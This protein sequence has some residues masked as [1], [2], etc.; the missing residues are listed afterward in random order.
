MNNL[1]AFITS[2]TNK[3]IIPFSAWLTFE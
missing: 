2:T 3:W 1:S